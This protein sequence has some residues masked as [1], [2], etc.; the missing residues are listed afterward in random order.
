[1]PD[2]YFQ[3]P[4]LT[5]DAWFTSPVEVREAVTAVT[6]V[7]HAMLDYNDRLHQQLGDEQGVSQSELDAVVQRRVPPMMG[8]SRSYGRD[9]LGL[10]N[11]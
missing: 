9:E 4:P 2:R 5:L 7:Y 1:M 10:R 6:R 3:I 11:S 8:Q